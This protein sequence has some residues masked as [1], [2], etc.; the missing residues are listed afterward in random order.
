MAQ[1]QSRDEICSVVSYDPE[2]GFFTRNSSGK[3]ADTNMKIGYKRV[4]MTLNGEKCEFY[5]HRLAWLIT[6]GAWPEAE[7]DHIDGKRGN[8]SI[9]NLRAVTRSENAKNIKLRDGSKSGFPGVV[10]HQRGWKVL[11]GREYVGFHG[12][13]AKACAARKEAQVASGYHENHGR[14]A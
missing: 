9:L 13:L 3:R 12:C 7:I 11:V 2:T 10:R 8:N 14:M 1:L 5:A 4:R 6:H